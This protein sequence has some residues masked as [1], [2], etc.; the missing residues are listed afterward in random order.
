VPHRE[1]PGRSVA[2]LAWPLVGRE[3]ELAR[4]DRARERGAAG[5]V[6]YAEAGMGK[7]RL[8][9]HVVDTAEQAGAMG[10]WVRATRG[11]A[12]IPAAALAPLLAPGTRADDPLEFIRGFASTMRDQAAGR[13]IVLGVDDAQLLDPVSASAL[14]HLADQS[15]A[16]V[17]ATI[18]TGETP[19]D[20]VTALWK[21]AG[22]VRLDLGAL[23]AAE[24][25]DLVEA[26]LDGP[27]EQRAHRWI[28]ESSRGNVLYAQ[29]LVTAAL[30]SDA[31]VRSEDLWRLEGRPAQNASLSELIVTRIG[32]LDGAQ[33]RGMELI[34]LGEPLALTDATALIGGDVLASLESLGLATVEAPTAGGEVRVAHP[35]FGESAVAATPV[36]RG[37]E[38]RIQLAAMLHAR[39]EQSGADALRIAQWLS[40]AG[41]P[42]PAEV[43]VRAARAAQI[44][45]STLTSQF[46]RLALEAGAGPEATL[47]LARAR[48]VHAEPAEAEA[49]LAAV[50]GQFDAPALAG[51]YLRERTTNLVWGLDRGADAVA[52]VDRAR[53]WFASEVWQRGVGALRLQLM[54][55]VEEP[56]AMIAPLEQALATV[57][58]DPVS[59]RWVNR[60]LIACLFWSGRVSEAAAM[61]PTLT[62]SIPIEEELAGVEFATLAVIGL[63]SGADLP[64][65]RRDMR[66]AFHTAIETSDPLAAGLAAFTVGAV[67][68]M[69]G[70]FADARRWLAEAVAQADRQDVYRVRAMARALQI[71]VLEALRDHDA[72]T[73]AVEHLE[74]EADEAPRSQR[75]V[76]AWI[77]RGGAWAALADGDPPRAQEILAA[78]A[79]AHDWAPV[80]AAELRYE[81]LRAG[82][83]AR[84]VAPALEAL[85]AR[86][87]GPLT[88]AYADHATARAASD[89]AALLA[90]AEALAGLGVTRYAAEAAAHASAAFAQEGREDSARRAAARSHELQPADQG[91]PPIAI[92]GVDQAASELTPRETQ[93]VE[94]AARGL[95]NAE[96]ADRLVL[97]TRTVET[98]I[99]RAMRKLG[100]SD[101]HDFRRPA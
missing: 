56:A 53:G 100:I 71:S 31:L 38:H 18:R 73:V 10:C 61:L 11:T 93:L 79:E 82:A 2:E 50:E 80:L 17:V 39:P 72:A 96:I 3:D 77:A 88:A 46:A 78:A 36:A 9:R 64:G 22:A 26:A 85:R 101:R 89:G 49:M 13:R 99:Y 74:A 91:A 81:A 59:R 68:A 14:L 55:H 63:S 25:A 6:V 67:D 60:A 44:A 69:A 66:A 42:I 40:D 27:V 65:L 45:G 70:R 34:A 15:V 51:E 8:A 7:T 20:A 95:T 41:E 29:Q 76:A 21:D 58:L 37:R 84:T 1:E 92:D 5:V 33:T 94:L 32:T 48:T 75:G 52:L 19:P 12:E 24:L 98:H 4:I 62:P 86:C 35:L 30:D 28:A 90:A 23:S 87:D 57:G 16:F 43:L 97:S 54:I 83:P 47:V